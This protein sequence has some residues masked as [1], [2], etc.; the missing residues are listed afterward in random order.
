MC[1]LDICR[2]PIQTKWLSKDPSIH[3]IKLNATKDLWHSKI[4]CVKTREIPVMQSEWKMKK[5][6]CDNITLEILKMEKRRAI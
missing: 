3:S 2:L 1:I 6:I 5:A 4:I